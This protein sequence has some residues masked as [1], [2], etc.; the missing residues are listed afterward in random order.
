ME[1]VE[2]RTERIAKRIIA[3]ATIW[4]KSP[5]KISVY[6]GETVSG[7]HK[8]PHLHVGYGRENDGSIRVSDGELVEG[9]LPQNALLPDPQQTD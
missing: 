9:N 3:M 8:E 1:N 6:P 2:D 4:Q 7:K 5:Y